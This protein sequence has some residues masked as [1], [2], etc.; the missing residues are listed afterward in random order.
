MAPPAFSQD[1]L[2][3]FLSDVRLTLHSRDGMKRPLERDASD[4]G[5]VN[6]CP[7]PS[8][9]SRMRQMHVIPRLEAFMNSRR[10]DK[11]INHL[12]VEFLANQGEHLSP[13][14]HRQYAMTI[15]LYES[16]LER[17]WPGRSREEY[18]ATARTDGTFCST[19]GAEDLI[20]GFSGFLDDFLPHEIDADAETMRV[21]GT[22]LK[23]LGSWLAAKGYVGCHETTRERVN[24]VTRDLLATQELLNLFQ[25]W[26][27][28]TGPADDFDDV[29]DHFLIHRIEPRQI[30]LESMM[31]GEVWGPIVVPVSIARACRVSWDIGGVIVHS[32]KGW[33]LIKVWNVSP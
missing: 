4:M 28:E 2:D 27:A 5:L 20:G 25:E 33:R 29:E 7:L 8:S 30:W 19:F 24:G 1:Q 12:F 26:L 15:D 17:Y 6:T 10:P 22:V 13:K 11:T 32:R 3:E 16:Y 31:A 9:R 23:R 14:S 21:A 18:N